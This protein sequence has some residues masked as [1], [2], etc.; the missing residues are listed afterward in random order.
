[1]RFPTGPKLWM[2]AILMLAAGT[3]RAEN[4]R[5]ESKVYKIGDKNKKPITEITTI[6]ADNVVYDVLVD[7]QEDVIPRR[8]SS[9]SAGEG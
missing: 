8:R 6:F 3:V 4:F 9:T 5:V 7:P 1:M 2:A